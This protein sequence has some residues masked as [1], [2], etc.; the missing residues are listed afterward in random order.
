MKYEKPEKII[1][2]IEE[3]EKEIQRGIKDLKDLL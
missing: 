1:S 3:I 2:K